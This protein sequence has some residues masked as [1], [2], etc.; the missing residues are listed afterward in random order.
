M[1]TATLHAGRSLSDRLKDP[2]TYIK[3]GCLAVFGT[4]TVLDLG[5]AVLIAITW[6]GWID[7]LW[8]VFLLGGAVFFGG[9]FASVLTEAW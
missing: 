7:L 9:M 6:Q 8:I 4:M 3:G 5:L 2:E 1:T